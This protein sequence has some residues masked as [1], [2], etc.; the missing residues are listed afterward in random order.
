MQIEGRSFQKLELPDNAMKIILKKELFPHWRAL[1]ERIISEDCCGRG[2]V[3]D[4][5][6]LLVLGSYKSKS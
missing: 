5:A 2:H 1:A 3:E 6:W 4:K